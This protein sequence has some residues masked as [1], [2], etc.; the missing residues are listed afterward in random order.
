MIWFISW[1]LLLR[2]RIIRE[3]KHYAVMGVR[4]FKIY[5]L[6]RDDQI[7]VDFNKRVAETGAQYKLLSTCMEHSSLQDCKEPIL[8]LSTSRGY[9]VW[10]N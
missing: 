7:A 5:F 1:L 2:L 9:V 6:D 10:K 8:T 3:C 4:G